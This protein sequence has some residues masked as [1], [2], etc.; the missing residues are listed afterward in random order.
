MSGA[1][2]VRLVDLRDKMARPGGGVKF[3]G[4]MAREPGR[5]LLAAAGVDIRAGLP[6]VVEVSAC[7]SLWVVA[8]GRD[9]QWYYL[10]VLEELPGGEA[11]VESFVW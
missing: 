10:Q 6:P 2:I 3:E 9:R 4:P 7:H 5:R 8:R 11:R 1:E